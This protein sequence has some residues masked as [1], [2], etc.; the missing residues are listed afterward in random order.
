[1]CGADDLGIHYLDGRRDYLR[2]P[3]CRLI[4]VPAHQ[5][6]SPAAERAE[7]DRHR[8]DVHDPGYRRF[9]GR[10][11]P[12]LRARRPPPAQGLDFGC[13]PGPALVTL[14]RE[15]GYAMAAYDPFYAPDARLLARDYDFI[16]AT[17]VVEHLARPGETLGRLWGCLRPG[18]VLAIMTQ[19]AREAWRFPT[20]HYVRDPTHVAFFSADTFRWLARRWGARLSFPGADLAFLEK[21]R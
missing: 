14:L 1:M 17:E 20:W 7:Y 2:C 6:L 15:A 10:I 4:H 18:G 8:N 3:R 16:T 19:R 9:L 12:P 21:P 13:G 5:H 11:L